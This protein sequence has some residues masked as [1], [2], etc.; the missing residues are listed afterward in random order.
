MS[1]VDYDANANAYKIA[2]NACVKLENKAVAVECF[3]QYLKLS[4]N[5]KDAAQIKE[6]INIL[7]K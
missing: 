4:P 1:S 7:K 3:E 6:T 2:G 5:A